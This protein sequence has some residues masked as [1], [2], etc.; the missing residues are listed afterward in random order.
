[1]YKAERGNDMAK[2]VYEVEVKGQKQKYQ[3]PTIGEAKEVAK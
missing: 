2:K 3:F 1:V